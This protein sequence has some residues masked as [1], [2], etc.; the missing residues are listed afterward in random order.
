VLASG[1]HTL[2]LHDDADREFGYTAGAEESLDRASGQDWT[3]VSM[4]SDW[5]TV[6]AEAPPR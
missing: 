2:A 3:V 1:N 4:K 5:S 6:F